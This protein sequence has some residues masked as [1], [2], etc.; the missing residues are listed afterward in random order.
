MKFYLVNLTFEMK[1]INI[2]II[3]VINALRITI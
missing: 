2:Y 3:I 1:T